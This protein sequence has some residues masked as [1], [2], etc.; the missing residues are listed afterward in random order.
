[1]QVRDILEIVGAGSAFLLITVLG[2]RWGWYELIGG[3]NKLLKEQNAELWKQNGF[4]KTEIQDNLRK[5]DE[6]KADWTAKHLESEKSIAN[7]QGKIDTLTKIPLN[8]INE[9]LTKLAD[10]T[11]KNAETNSKNAK[12]SGQ[13]LTLMQSNAEAAKVVAETLADTK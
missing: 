12:I 1:M 8:S 4:L 13:I 2:K 9:T 5:Y 6:D 11:N 7:L 10:S 3:T